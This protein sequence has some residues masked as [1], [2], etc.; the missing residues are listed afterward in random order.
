M[1]LDPEGLREK[2]LRDFE[3]AGGTHVVLVH[4]PYREHPITRKEDF[5]RSFRV[6][7]ELADRARKRTGVK[8]LVAVGPYPVNLIYLA[9]K[10]GLETAVEIMEYGMEK[11][12]GLV[13]GGEA[14]AIGE[15]GRP[16]FPVD[17]AI[18][19][20]SNRILGYG[21]RLARETGCPVHL[22]TEGGGRKL[23]AELAVMAREAGCPPD[24]VIK[25]FS[26]PAVSEEENCGLFPSVLASRRNVEEALSKGTRFC[27]ETDYIDD[28]KRPGAVM[29]PKSI[30][31]RTFRMMEKGLLSEE[32]AYKIHKEWPERLYGVE[33]EV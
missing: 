2:V 23:F 13:E 19:K 20:A 18:L 21:L 9:E 7:L 28:L 25:H 29:V 24:K 31:K 4:K 8:V 11:A 17:E 22:H 1:H 5:K 3:N 14:N 16:H 33:I 12:A 32:G 27:M 30:P 15:I 26:G 6:T 10:H